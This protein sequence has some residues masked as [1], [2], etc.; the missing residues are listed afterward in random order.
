VSDVTAV[1]LNWNSAA[2]TIRCLRAVVGGSVV[3]SVVVVDNGSTDDSL[4]RLDEV[5]GLCTVVRN[6]AN[7]GYAG[8][9]NTGLRA[10]RQQ[11]ARWVWLLN[12]DSVPRPDALEQL[13]AHAASYAVLASLQV[14]SDSPESTQAQAY[15]VAAMLPNGR[16]RPFECT[17]CAAAHHRVDVV[18]GASILFD[19]EAA[20]GVGLFDESFFHYKEEF[21]FIV[22]I[23]RAGGAVGLA[24]TSVVWHQ[25]GGSLSP[26]SPRAGYYFHRNEVL[27]IRKHY[28]RPILRL[29]SEPV[30]YKLAGRSFVSLVAP[31]RARRR[32]AAAVL[33]GYWDGVRGVTGPTER[34]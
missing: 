5:A 15:T 8:G 27:Y 11:G 14:S 31:D 19:I 20:F 16:V 25:R 13:L 10:A 17:G 28:K 6:A 12:A 24:C 34:F 23:G 30:H 4:R 18:S 21:D 3:P 2:D 29:L 22:R 7:L 1:I 26:A 32:R 9:M 33:A